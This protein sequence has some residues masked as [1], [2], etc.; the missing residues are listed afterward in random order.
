MANNRMWLVHRPTGEAFCL[1]KRMGHG[2][3][4]TT[5]ED[6][7]LRS[8]FEDLASNDVTVSNQDDFVLAM[9]TV[10]EGASLSVVEIVR[11][12]FDGEKMVPKI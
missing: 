9:D 2:W 12:D 3:Y 6:Y 1:A 4:R 11:Y 8:W 7:T 10:Q 5:I